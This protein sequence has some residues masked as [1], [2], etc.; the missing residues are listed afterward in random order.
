MATVPSTAIDVVTRRQ[1]F[2]EGL[3]TGEANRLLTFLKSADSSIRDRLAGRELTELSRERLTRLLASVEDDLRTVYSGFTAGLRDDLMEI[4]AQESRF[5]GKL[6]NDMAPNYEPVIP[7]V[8]QVKSAV[9]AAPLGIQGANGGKLLTPFLRS[10]TDSEV[11]RLLGV[12][13][14]GAFEG[15]TN[16]QI[17]RAVRGTAAANYRDGAL[18]IS[19]RAASSV[20]R[21]TVQHIATNARMETYRDNADIVKGYQWVATLDSRTS[22]TCQALDGRIFDIGKGPVPPAHI[23]CRSSTVPVLDSRFDLLDKG[24]TRASQDGPVDAKETYYGWLKRQPAEF[25]AEAIGPGRA[26]LLRD[27]GLTANEFA[28]L[29][30]DKNFNPITLERMQELDPLAF[31]RAGLDGG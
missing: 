2:L 26:K 29:Q 12:I 20:V 17:V 24:A 11:D 19:E 16:A 23:G 4:A 25:Q 3:K 27:G 14:T 10:F 1:V 21:T 28:R 5:A 31:K 6:L 8:G 22:P 7:T 30:L 15:Q 13:R 9:L 18:A